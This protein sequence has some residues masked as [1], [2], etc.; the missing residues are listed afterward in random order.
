MT[1]VNIYIP[2]GCMRLW[3]D[4]IDP[5]RWGERVTIAD[6]INN[7]RSLGYIPVYRD[8][9]DLIDQH[10]DVPYTVMQRTVRDDN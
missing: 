2:I 7:P 1:T 10:G 4:V 5:Q 3:P 8:L 6:A 9:A